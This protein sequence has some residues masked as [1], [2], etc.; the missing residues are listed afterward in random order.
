M[1]KLKN[2]NVERYLDLVKEMGGN[3]EGQ[4]GNEMNQFRRGGSLPTYGDG[5]GI[6]ST[7]QD[8]ATEVSDVYNTITNPSYSNDRFSI[9]G[10]IN[11]DVNVNWNPEG[12]LT[13]WGSPIIDMGLSGGVGGSYKLNDRLTFDA[14]ANYE[15]GNKPSYSAG[16]TYNFKQGGSLPKAQTLGESSYSEG[17]WIDGMFYPNQVQSEMIKETTSN[18]DKT[19]TGNKKAVILYDDNDTQGYFS[20]DLERMTPHLNKKY[21]EGNW[22]AHGTNTKYNDKYNADLK[23]TQDALDADPIEIQRKLWFKQYMNNEMDGE[24]YDRLKIAQQSNE[25]YGAYE[26]LRDTN[27]DMFNLRNKNKLSSAE[28][29]TR[30][31]SYIEGMDPNGE[32][33]IMQHGDGKIG[34]I[35]PSELSRIRNREDQGGGY[36]NTPGVTDTF[37]EVLKEYLPEDNN[38]VCYMGSCYQTDE[39]SEITQESG[40]TTKSQLGSW[41]GFQNREKQ[42][43]TDQTF[44]EMFFDPNDFSKTGG[45]Y[46]TSTLDE[47]GNLVNTKTGKFAPRSFSNILSSTNDDRGLSNECK[48]CLT[49]EEMIE[50]SGEIER[51]FSKDYEKLINEKVAIGNDKEKLE[52]WYNNLIKDFKQGGSLPKAQ[53]GIEKFQE[54]GS[55]IEKLKKFF[56]IF[57][58][59][60]ESG[61]DVIEMFLK[62]K[63]GEFQTYEEL[64][65]EPEGTEKDG[66]YLHYTEDG[67]QWLDHPVQLTLEQKMSEGLQ[68]ENPE[69]NDRY[70]YVPGIGWVPVEEI[71]DATKVKQID[72]GF[73]YPNREEKK[74]LTKEVDYF[75]PTKI[76]PMGMQSLPTN[77]DDDQLIKAPPYDLI[78]HDSDYYTIEM[79]G[80]RGGR[81]IKGDDGKSEIN[82]RDQAGRLIWSGT[83]TEYEELYGDFLERGTTEYGDKRKSRLYLKKQ[84]GGS[85][86]KAQTGYET[87]TDQELIDYQKKNFPDMFKSRKNRGEIKY[88]KWDINRIRSHIEST[89]RLEK[90]DAGYAKNTADREENAKH[91]KTAF[92]HLMSG[93]QGA[94]SA[95]KRTYDYFTGDDTWNDEPDF[96]VA[97]NKARTELGD[98]GEFLWNNQLKTTATK[99][100]YPDEMTRDFWEVI[101]P[102]DPRFKDYPGSIQKLKDLWIELGMKQIWTDP[103]GRYDPD[104]I[105]GNWEGTTQG[106]RP[107]TRTYNNIIDLGKTNNN[108]TNTGG[109]FDTVESFVDELTHLMFL[110]KYSDE[111]K[112]K[113]ERSGDWFANEGRTMLVDGIKGNFND[114]FG[115]QDEKEKWYSGNSQSDVELYLKKFDDETKDL[116]RE[117][118]KNPNQ[119]TYNNL[120]KHAKNFRKSKTEVTFGEWRMDDPKS[121]TDHFADAYESTYYTEG[122]EEHKHKHGK[123][124]SPFTGNPILWNGEEVE[125]ND[126]ALWALIGLDPEWRS[127]DT[128]MKEDGAGTGAGRHKQGSLGRKDYYDQQD[129]AYDKTIDINA[130][131]AGTDTY[132]VNRDNGN[133]ELDNLEKY[134][135]LSEVRAQEYVNQNMGLFPYVDGKQTLDKSISPNHYELFRGV[136]SYTNQF[137]DIMKRIDQETKFRQMNNTFNVDEY[138]LDQFRDI[139]TIFPDY[140]YD[141]D[142]KHLYRKG[143]EIVKHTIVKGDTGKRLKA[144]YGTELKDILKHNDL[145]YFKLGA[146]IE[147]PKF[148]KKGSFNKKVKNLFRTKKQKKIDE[149]H[150]KIEEGTYYEEPN[151]VVVDE[152][153]TYGDSY[154]LYDID[155]NDEDKGH[156]STSYNDYVKNIELYGIDVANQIYMREG[157]SKLPTEVIQS[158][159]TLGFDPHSGQFN[160]IDKLNK[161]YNVGI[162]GKNYLP[163]GFDFNTYDPDKAWLDT[164]PGTV[165]EIEINDDKPTNIKGSLNSGDILNGWTPE[166]TLEELKHAAT[167]DTWNP[168]MKGTGH[169]YNPLN[170]AAAAGFAQEWNWSDRVHGDGLGIVDGAWNYYNNIDNNR[171][172]DPSWRFGNDVRNISDKTGTNRVFYADE[173]GN[174]VGTHYTDGTPYTQRIIDWAGE[175][176]DQNLAMTDDGSKIQEKYEFGED[177]LYKYV[178]V[179]TAAVTAPY[180]APEAFALGSANLTRWAGTSI[181]DALGYYGGYLGATALPDDIQEFID[182]PS[183]SAA[184][185]I[186]WDILGVAGGMFST[187]NLAGNFRHA[188]KVDDVFNVVKSTPADDIINAKNAKLNS[189]IGVDDLYVRPGTPANVTTSNPKVIPSST[190]KVIPSSTEIVNPNKMSHIKFEDNVIQA[191]NKHVTQSYNMPKAEL[192]FSLTDD[193]VTQSN[194]SKGLLNNEAGIRNSYI[195]PLS[196]EGDDLVNLYRFGRTPTGPSLGPNSN[197]PGFYTTNPFGPKVYQNFRRYIKPGEDGGVFQVKVPA[198]DLKNYYANYKTGDHDA[199]ETLFQEFLFPSSITD[200]AINITKQYDNNSFLFNLKKYGGSLPRYKLRRKI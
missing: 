50:L 187:Y 30:Y 123:V 195:Q 76:P 174:P 124:L 139:N 92:G 69:V 159:S 108:I 71:P 75:S 186:G 26:T 181:F 121:F 144:M 67:P 83:Q 184:G 22:T 169:Y 183:W 194:Y 21:G 15:T 55:S 77:I 171:T 39:A 79:R 122:T 13:Q 149:L 58:N 111:D 136:E 16:L 127:L 80:K 133:L 178:P 164:A 192:K 28:I 36:T 141:S 118:K 9:Q 56:N 193:F 29:A 129:W 70:E 135:Y 54:G 74:K 109:R 68:F 46:Q 31:G 6:V 165:K 19:Y 154:N 147:I 7:L 2:S 188:D 163:E 175:N 35:M 131:V 98:K 86:P 78:K 11:P 33:I 138:N 8:T 137:D 14:S 113:F 132:R 43:G 140:G 87:W 130:G 100:D 172:Y 10:N 199:V 153:D 57:D 45:I 73:G 134:P 166:W 103:N 53:T 146:E 59:S 34:Q 3:G 107:T 25:G 161:K 72:V 167:K 99:E 12:N 152:L 20:S 5:S 190:E 84:Y 142:I 64:G 170:P 168:L 197:M 145:T 63:K 32:I 125:G 126:L 158:N 89:I 198:K 177:M 101:I 47:S 62:G 37:A 85:L 96:G 88:N 97:F 1:R 91:N 110:S 65:Y 150:Q 52:E 24:E 60:D 151:E 179:A 189:E 117:Y 42:Y 40:V 200:D 93:V 81:Y 49:E 143:G 196:G 90:R 104:G 112:G 66:K 38:V 27:S 51:L 94:Y 106:S 82:L 119:K 128:Y 191:T 180:W 148:Q 44:D 160:T 114:W 162:E 18:T 41:A 4:G 115:T 182:N 61:I 173:D 116:I 120:T 95:G 176:T 48:G 17:E 23:A 185:D 105:L 155:I 156:E 157:K 102:A